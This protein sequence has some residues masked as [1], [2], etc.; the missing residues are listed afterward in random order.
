MCAI[1]G[2]GG[3]KVINPAELILLRDRMMHRGPDDSGIWVREDHRVALGHRRLAI[4]DLSVAAQQ[5]MRSLSGRYVIVFNGE[6][7]NYKELRVRLERLGHHFHGT[8]DT[9]VVLAAFIEWGASCL[10][11]F[12]G[13][14]ALAIHDSGDS[15][16][17]ATLFFAR[18][19]AGKKPLYIAR[20]GRN[21][22]FASE[23]KS[24]PEDVR[25]GINISALNFY[26]AL[27][28]IPGDLSISQGVKKLPPAH[29]A[30]FQIESGEYHEWR[31]WTLPSPKYEERIDIEDLV[32]EAESL[33]H[34]AVRLRLRSDVPV[35]V[36]LS[37]GLDSS[38]LVASAAQN[39]GRVKTFTIGFPGSQLDETHYA[40]IVAN[41]FNTEHNV[42]SL[43]QSSLSVLEEMAPLLDEPL[44]DSSLIPTYLVSKMTANHVKVALGGD[45]GDELFGG[46][47]D[48]ITAMR[49]A[50]NLGIFPEILLKVTA[51]IAGQLPSGIR[52]RNRIYSLRGGVYQ[53]LVW[54]SPYFDAPS[55]RRILSAD[56]LKA[57]GGDFMAPERFRLNLFMNGLD[58][59]DCMTRTH[60]GS[61]LPD[62]FL[63][64]VDRASMAVGLEMRSPLLDYRLIEFAFGRIPSV[65][66]V[67]ANESRI[68]QKKLAQRLLPSQL[69][70]DRKQ[71]FS[72]PTNDWLRSDPE[73]LKIKKFHQLINPKEVQSQI[74]GHSRG[75]SNGARIYSLLMLQM[76]MNN[77]GLDL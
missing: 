23:L 53:S 51:L 7:Y 37:G 1:V 76:C 43:P 39:V 50:R 2:R 75:R 13:M 77:L 57:L 66:K 36:L 11:Y 27:G 72:I 49:D 63:V 10:S 20:H 70:I 15:V 55:R 21:I 28:Y 19:R 65:F 64:K 29:A 4:L 59:V 46:Y 9:E 69:D 16:T 56:A 32:N 33:V 22:Y 67:N 68:L 74:N 3:D 45:G 31:W 73:V 48:Y 12:N 14:F 41:Y 60:F 54:G 61:I 42:I 47:S 6:I 30:I 35:G 44:A 17:P 62:D 5:P 26:L 34:D 40:N 8:G 71:G 24:I 52:G 58:P 38:I 25:G 18:D